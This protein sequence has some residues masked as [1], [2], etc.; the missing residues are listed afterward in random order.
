MISMGKMATTEPASASRRGVTRGA[1]GH[2]FAVE[3]RE[4]AKLAFPMVLAQLGQITMMTTDLAL[5]GRMGAE[6]LAAAALAGKIYCVGVT[7]GMGLLAAIGPIAAQAFGAGN[8]GVVRRSLRMGLW[9]ALLLSLP[10]MTFPLLGEQILLILGQAPAAARLAQQYLL[11]LAWGVAPAL[12]FLAIRSFMAGVKRPEPI[13]WITLAAIPVNAFLVYLLMYGKFGLPRLELFG[14]GFATT[15]VNCGMFSAAFWFATMRRPF[16]DYRALAH[17]W[18]F[19]WPL[20]RQ[21]I[22]V[23]APISAAFL[24]EYG[25]SSAAALLMGMISTRALAAHQIAF[26]V[27]AILFMIPSG[28]SMA[29]AVRVAQA[30]GCK[31]RPGIKRA[32][33]AAM[34]LGIVIVVMLTLAV[35]A[36]RFKIG[37]VLL[38]RSVDD[39]DAT[40]GL[41]AHLL[42]IGASSFITAAM[43]CIASGCLRGLKD[44]WVPLLFAGIAYWLIGLS[45]SYLLGVKVGLGPIGI[46]IGLSIGTTVY[47]VLLVARFLLLAN[48]LALQSYI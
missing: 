9:A 35:I 14:A 33:L 1:G 11:G 19:E 29:A 39:A 43:Y 36:A 46:W 2:Q 32:G 31:D 41:A 23:G 24:M 8:L 22:I 15:L 20:M 45:S 21:L 12:W 16:R 27:A 3:L 28:I 48:R 4:I 7:F 25:I 18:R 6:A 38:D 44:T 34:V 40:I 10:I 47:A 26:Q 30:V 42:S 5:I 13:L 17:L 37:E